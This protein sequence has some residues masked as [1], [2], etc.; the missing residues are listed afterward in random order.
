MKLLSLPMFVRI[1]MY[2]PSYCK[3]FCWDV[4]CHLCRGRHAQAINAYITKSSKFAW[5][6]NWCDK[7]RSL[8]NKYASLWNHNISCIY[9][10]KYGLTLNKLVQKVCQSIWLSLGLLNNIVKLYENL[11]LQNI[12]FWLLKLSSFTDSAWQQEGASLHS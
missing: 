4:C 3:N 11:M 6:A 7:P 5:R 10:S 12:F 8:K 1:C 9:E 2:L